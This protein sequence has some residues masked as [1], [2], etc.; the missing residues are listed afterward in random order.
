M[1]RTLLPVFTALAL[2]GCGGGD[3]T[4]TAALDAQRE[5]A[6]KGSITIQPG[7]PNPVTIWHEVAIN[8]INVP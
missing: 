1:K 2:A 5:L 3:S 6:Q 7:A 4:E 8:T